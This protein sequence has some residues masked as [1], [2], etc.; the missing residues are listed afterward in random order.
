MWRGLPAQGGSSS[1]DIITGRLSRRGVG[2]RRRGTHACSAAESRARRRGWHGSRANGHGTARSANMNLRS[3]LTMGDLRRHTNSGRISVQSERA[4]VNDWIDR[5]GIVTRGT[6]VPI[7]SLSGGNQQKVLVARATASHAACARARRSDRGYRCR[8]S[9]TGARHHRAT[10]HRF[11]VGAP[12]LDRQRRARPP[13]RPRARDGARC[14][15]HGIAPRDRPHC[16]EHR[17][18][19]KSLGQ[20][21]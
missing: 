16:R 11:D 17:P 4:E 19:A 2:N 12:G 15:R 20:P 5:L 13:V 6:D 18:R 3:N 9:R 21:T 8:R 7:T 10:H 1:L 14:R